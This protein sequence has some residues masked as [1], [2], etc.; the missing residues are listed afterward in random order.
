[1]NEI[2]KVAQASVIITN[3]IAKMEEVALIIYERN[4]ELF[5][6]FSSCKQSDEIWIKN[7]QKLLDMTG[8]VSLGIYETPVPQCR[9][10]N[11]SI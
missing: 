6:Y 8:D 11:I 1:M 4:N 3:Q 7:A 5:S 9:Y 2:G 10:T